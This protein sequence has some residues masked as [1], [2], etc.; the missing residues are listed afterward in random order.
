MKYIIGFWVVLFM[1]ALIS[2]EAVVISF[3]IMVVI[4]VVYHLSD[5]KR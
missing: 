5:G 3:T 1:S 2:A 4:T